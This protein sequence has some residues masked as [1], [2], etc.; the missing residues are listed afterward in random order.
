VIAVVVQL[1]LGL[2]ALIYLLPFGGVPRPV[3]LYEAMFRTG[4]QT[5][6][7]IF[8]ASTVVLA[9]RARRHLLPASEGLESAS[10]LTSATKSGQ[11]PAS[12]EVVG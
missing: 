8:L 3:S 5:N 7:A 2:G 12:L 11:A 6:A 4:H 1:L 9:L 10:N